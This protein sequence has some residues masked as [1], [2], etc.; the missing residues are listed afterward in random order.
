[1][2]FLRRLLLC[3]GLL[4]PSALW[5][6]PTGEEQYWLELINRARRDPAGEVERQVNFSSPTSFGLPSSDNADVVNALAYFGTSATELLAQWSTLGSVSP[7]AWNDALSVSA[8]NYSQLMVDMDMQLHF[9]DGLDIDVRIA[10]SYGKNFLVVGETLYATMQ[11]IEHGHAAFMIDWGDDDANPGNG[12]GA[13]VQSSTTN[14]TGATHREVLLDANVKQIGMGWITVVQPTSL[15]SA[16][17]PCVVT[18]HLGSKC[19]EDL[20]TG[21]FFSGAILAWRCLPTPC[22]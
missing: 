20:G 9:L 19:R 4:Q 11:S 5:A 8:T 10:N 13:G 6:D 22:W 15:N 18:Q 21:L 12:F 3:L 7:L 16:R 2:T 17:G 14:G 1:M